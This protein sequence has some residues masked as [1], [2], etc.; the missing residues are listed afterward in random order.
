MERCADE[1]EETAFLSPPPSSSTR[2]SP[3]QPHPPLPVPSFFS[4][5]SPPALLDVQVSCSVCFEGEED[6]E[7]GWGGEELMLVG[8]AED[9]EQGRRGR[10]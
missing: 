7:E 4:L 8:D 5:P 2:P 3:P 10:R 1:V 6:S 9:A